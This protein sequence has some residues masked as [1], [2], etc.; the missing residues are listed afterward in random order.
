MGFKM[1]ITSQHGLNL[2]LFLIL[3]SI[4]VNNLFSYDLFWTEPME[5]HV[6]FSEH[7]TPMEPILH[8]YPLKI[9]QTKDAIYYGIW[10]VMTEGLEDLFFF[11]ST[12][13]HN[14]WFNFISL[15]EIF[16]EIEGN[17]RNFDFILLENDSIALFGV[18]STSQLV[19]DTWIDKINV[20]MS[21]S[22]NGGMSW[23]KVVQINSTDLRST[24][25]GVYLDDDIKFWVIEEDSGGHIIYIRIW[26]FN[27]S[28]T[29][30]IQTHVYQPE[31]NY[32]IYWGGVTFNHQ[33]IF[34]ERGVNINH[35]LIF[36]GTNWEQIPITLTEYD[37]ERITVIR[38]TLYLIYTSPNNMFY[39]GKVN[40]E[41]QGTNAK[42]TGSTKIIAGMNWNV[43]WPI[44]NSTNT[45][46]YFTTH[47]ND[48]ASVR[49]AFNWS[50]VLFIL[51]FS[52]IFI[53]IWLWPIFSSYLFM[54]KEK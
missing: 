36:D 41:D 49:N 26:T 40:I 27:E 43:I 6:D 20:I 39:I 3:G 1:K 2:F 14:Q 38:S 16:S 8:T 46:F 19:N 32:Q 52:L 5:T 15:D 10:H 28:T 13:D 7:T 48:I 29:T 35:L 31:T 34:L 23:S 50:T 22:D 42:I 4:I 18:V 45:T 44:V 30:I 11:G 17:L 54:E 21:L 24:Y 51:L 33:L 53:L 25:F 37:L 47:R 12:N 9:I